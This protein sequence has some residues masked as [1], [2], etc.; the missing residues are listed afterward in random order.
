LKNLWKLTS[1]L[2]LR[3]EGVKGFDFPAGQVHLEDD[4]V[5]LRLTSGGGILV[6]PLTHVY[7]HASVPVSRGRW[8]FCAAARES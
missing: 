5:F 8:R 6:L 3:Q 7:L 1:T 2:G 4:P